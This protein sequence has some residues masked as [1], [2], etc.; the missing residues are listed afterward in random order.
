MNEGGVLGVDRGGTT[1]LLRRQAQAGW[2]RS[3]ISFSNRESTAPW[4]AA[5]GP[6]TTTSPGRHR[7]GEAR[8][9]FMQ[10]INAVMTWR[11]V[12]AHLQPHQRHVI[13]PVPYGDACFLL[14]CSLN[15]IRQLLQCPVLMSPE[16]LNA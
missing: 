5:G 2:G 6:V 7:G 13:T 1:E 4:P 15:P 8:G 14:L 12:G 10:A 11:R 16:G 3:A 9:G